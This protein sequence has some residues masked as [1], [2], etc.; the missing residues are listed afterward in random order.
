MARAFCQSGAFKKQFGTNL[1]TVTAPTV[2]CSA[3]GAGT[4]PDSIAVCP[5]NTSVT[6]GGYSLTVYQPYNTGYAWLDSN[7][8]DSSYPTGNNGWGVHSGGAPGNSCFRAVATC[9]Y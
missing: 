5:L 9:L 3:N 4:Q 8:P 1:I 7:A 2:N 6:G